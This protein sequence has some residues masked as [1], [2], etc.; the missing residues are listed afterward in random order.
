MWQVPPIRLTPKST[1]EF[2]AAAVNTEIVLQTGEGGV[3]TGFTLQQNGQQ[4]T[5][6]KEAHRT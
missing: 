6:S 3:V 1:K 5:A 4:I 2:F